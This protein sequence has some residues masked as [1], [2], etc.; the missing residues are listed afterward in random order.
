[1][2]LQTINI[3]VCCWLAVAVVV[4]MKSG[5]CCFCFGF[6]ATSLDRDTWGLKRTLNILQH[7]S[8]KHVLAHETCNFNHFIAKN[9][10]KKQLFSRLLTEPKIYTADG[11]GFFGYQETHKLLPTILYRP[12]NKPTNNHLRF[13]LTYNIP[14]RILTASS[15]TQPVAYDLL[16]TKVQ[17]IA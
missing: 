1:M 9:L 3:F 11:V 14:L 7:W 13:F 16:S 8:L 4:V 12:F 2:F 6:I 5:I 10:P 17:L 15:G